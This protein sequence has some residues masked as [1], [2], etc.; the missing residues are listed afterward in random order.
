MAKS[1]GLMQQWRVAAPKTGANDKQSKDFS[2]AFD[3]GIR[4]IGDHIDALVPIA[5]AQD[6]QKLR[7]RHENLIKAYQKVRRGIDPAKPS[8][9]EKDIDKV[10]EAL[11][12]AKQQSGQLR[13]KIET[14]YQDWLSY[15]A[16]AEDRLRDQI[17]A[18][19]A[20]GE[21]RATELLAVLGKADDAAQSHYWTKAKARL[22]DLDGTMKP[23]HE[24]YLKQK[25][26]KALYDADRA[27]FDQRVEQLARFDT[28]TEEFDAGFKTVIKAL[29][30]LDVA[31]ETRDFVA[32]NGAMKKIIRDLGLLEW[33]VAE[34]TAD[35]TAFQKRRQ[36]V[37]TDLTFAADLSHTAK[38]VETKDLQ[39]AV[40]ALDDDLAA[41]LD[42]VEANLKMGPLEQMVAD[43]M[44][45]IKMHY[46]DAQW[47]GT[48]YQA[49][50]PR[51]ARADDAPANTLGNDYR[52]N[53]AQYRGELEKKIAED[54]FTKAL[55]DLTKIEA[56]LAAFESFMA[57]H[58][59]E[60]TAYLARFGAASTRLSK[61]AEP[62][63]DRMTQLY[64]VIAALRT[65]IEQDAEEFEYGKALNG[66]DQAESLI[67][68][69]E[70]LVAALA[71]DKAAYE[72][73]YRTLESRVATCS[74][75]VKN[76]PDFAYVSDVIATR[77]EAEA[78][79]A[80]DK[81]H[82]ALGR[83]AE[84]REFLVL[85]EQTREMW[86]EKSAA[87]DSRFAELASRIKA[88]MAPIE[89]REGA[90]L[91]TAVEAPRK[92][93]QSSY[94]IGDYQDTLDK[95]IELEGALVEI[96]AF[97]D[98]QDEERKLYAAR[99]AE[100]EQRLQALEG[101]TGDEGIAGLQAAAWNKQRDAEEAARLAQFDN[102]LSRLREAWTATDSL[103]IA[104][105]DFEAE[106]ARYEARKTALA[107]RMKEA[108]KPI[109]RDWASELQ[110]EIRQLGDENSTLEEAARYE[111]A[112]ANQDVLESRIASL[113]AAK[114]M[115]DAGSAKVKDLMKQ[116]QKRL[117]KLEPRVDAAL[118]LPEKA[119]DEKTKNRL[120][121]WR[122]SATIEDGSAEDAL[123]AIE[124]GE[125]LVAG[126][127]VAKKRYDEAKAQYDK[128]SAALDPRI[129]KISMD[130]DDQL[131]YRA[132]P[133]YW[134]AEEMRKLAG[135]LDY[136][137]ALAISDRVESFITVY[138]DSLTAMNEEE[139]VYQGHLKALA[140]RL[141]KAVSADQ[142][143]WA[144]TLMEDIL[145]EKESM[146]ESA[147]EGYF[148]DATV[149]AGKLEQLLA[150]YENLV[151]KH[152]AFEVEYQRRLPVAL[153]RLTQ[154]AA[155]PR[156]EKGQVKLE[157]LKRSRAAMEEFASTKD[158]QTASS[159]LEDLEAELD[160]YK[161]TVTQQH[162]L[163][164]SNKSRLQSA[165]KRLARLAGQLGDKT[166]KA[167]RESIVEG[168][169]K[170]RDS[171]QDPRTCSFLLDGLE[172]RL[173]GY[174]TAVRDVED[175]TRVV[176]SRLGSLEERVNA[177]GDVKPTEEW[178]KAHDKLLDYDAYAAKAAEEER[179][180]D[181]LEALDAV[182]ELLGECEV[183]LNKGLKAA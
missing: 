166:L 91:Q 120:T 104:R 149:S 17:D 22:T 23:L 131:H 58:E 90:A 74:K 32:A 40:K 85:A 176:Y 143:P 76:D 77:K 42:F 122:D 4:V 79:A 110:A 140:P 178:S 10:L 50:Q 82:L 142:G 94:K 125:A 71:S 151:E 13:K 59:T 173:D 7:E 83:L 106:K 43:Y 41:T 19:E 170:A 169:K 154:A 75:V 152:R 99:H 97:R 132:E 93:A 9:A 11:D 29:G 182:E 174:E 177:V 53:L 6:L 38:S 28:P 86:A 124:E 158:F 66:L 113:E 81:Y 67:V 164:E 64:E 109:D 62:A 141:R 26:A 108:L 33:L 35:K 51:L 84:L 175:K 34:I 183:Y 89:G 78:A 168:V 27:A 155:A 5:T 121:A 128:R 165:D 15:Q 116:V 167:T 181:A 8:K 134:A 127:E 156:V 80:K 88:A 179:Y 105:K 54:D 45:R 87:C 20:W 157:D 146:E 44:A 159:L 52:K 1:K 56:E 68:Q 49:L 130:K 144:K 60:R 172:A 61:L 24:N 107:P 2:E 96:E 31:T 150:R 72:A 36:I 55:E 112:V 126:C 137:K 161:V 139:I 92:E 136:Q 180:D 129:A 138:E 117:A 37:E 102:A 123:A 98:R 63:D 111:Q 3:P 46:D 101:D 30:P 103:A 148:G 25:S 118:A 145:E 39:A 153:E 119:I 95:L 160:L 57:E 147:T 21:P 69:Y 115:K 171:I 163:V 73:E 16:L 133:A 114:A 100:V 135:D 48:R 47:I 18:L 162:E 14:A 65:K 70:S 12:K